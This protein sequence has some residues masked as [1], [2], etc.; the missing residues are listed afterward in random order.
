MLIGHKS[1]LRR[2][3]QQTMQQLVSTTNFTQRRHF[4]AGN[5]GQCF[6]F[7]SR[8]STKRNTHNS[9]FRKYKRKCQLCDQ[10]G[11]MAK[12]CSKCNSF[13]FL[14]IMLHPLKARIRN[15]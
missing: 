6:Y 13:D 2:L 3:E 5:N 9:G 12:T 4:L 14:Q 1:Y 15:G 8:D 7:K 11:H 10:L